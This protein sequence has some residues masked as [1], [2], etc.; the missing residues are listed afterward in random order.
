[1]RHGIRLL[2]TAASIALSACVTAQQVNF[3]SG[4]Y[5]AALRTNAI[6][7]LVYAETPIHV[8]TPGSVAWAGLIDALTSPAG[9]RINVPSV[10]FLTAS[11]LREA[12]VL[13]ARLNVDPVHEK[14]LASRDAD[15]SL[16]AAGATRKFVL[17]VSCTD[18]ASHFRPTAWST[19]QY[20]L[21]V[22]AT[23]GFR[24]AG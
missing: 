22:R 13:R 19:Y 10:A 6:S 17:K 5:G 16:A 20:M 23:L 8:L 3:D 12:L 15:Q 24:L 21:H 2:L 9:G 18:N 14:L 7:V 1:M 11:F 4:V